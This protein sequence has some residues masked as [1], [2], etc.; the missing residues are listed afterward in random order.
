MQENYV[1]ATVGYQTPDEEL[2]LDYCRE[3]VAMEVPM[4]SA[5][6]DSAGTMRVFLLKR[7]GGEV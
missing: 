3:A 7:Y 4:H 6:P 2:D 5:I 1:H